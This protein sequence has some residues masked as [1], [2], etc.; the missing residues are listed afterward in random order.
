VADNTEWKEKS[1]SWYP[2][3]DGE[4][5]QSLFALG[6]SHVVRVV[7][8]IIAMLGG[9]SN[10]RQDKIGFYGCLNVAA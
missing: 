7:K 6:D 5:T 9:I 8:S 4:D 3:D 1:P 2:C 10:E